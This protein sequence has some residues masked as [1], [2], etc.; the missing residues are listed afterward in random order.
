MSFL[1]QLSKVCL[2]RKRKEKIMQ[3]KMYTYINCKFYEH[4]N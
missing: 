2:E 4:R 3:N 1:F